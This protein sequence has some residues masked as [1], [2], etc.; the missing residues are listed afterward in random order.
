MSNRALVVLLCLVPVRASALTQPGGAQIPAPMGCNSGKP[1]GLAAA[2]ACVCKDPG[3]CN[4]G[5]PCTAPGMCDSGVRSMCETTL[6]HAFNDNTCI[7]S[8]M[9]GLDPYQSASVLPETF[10]PSCPLTFT[11]VTR[12]TALF[13][14]VFGWYNRPGSAPATSELHV[15]LELQR[16]P[17]A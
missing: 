1:T 16:R 2:F 14:D 8:L 15:M 5:A 13:R 17:G 6:T 3:Q 7:P 11:V 12:G 4:I 9:S 10:R